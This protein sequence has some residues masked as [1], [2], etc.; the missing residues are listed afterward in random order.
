MTNFLYRRTALLPR[1]TLKEPRRAV[2]KS[3]V[4]AMRSGA[5]CFGFRGFGSRDSGAN[6]SGAVFARKSFHKFSIAAMHSLNLQPVPEVA[7]DS[8]T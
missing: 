2:G 3:T 6:Q 8:S 4:E 5:R 7:V 1:L